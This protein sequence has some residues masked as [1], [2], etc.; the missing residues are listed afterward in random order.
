MATLRSLLGASARTLEAENLPCLNPPQRRA[1]HGL[2]GASWVTVDDHPEGVILAPGQRQAFRLQAR[3]IVFAAEDAA[4]LLP[5]MDG[6]AIA[7]M[8]DGRQRRRP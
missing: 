5:D 3:A 2:R 1:I 4:F 7:V 8:S 6:V